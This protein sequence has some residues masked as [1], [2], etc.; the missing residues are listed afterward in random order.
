MYFEESSIEILVE[1]YPTS[2]KDA[3]KDERSTSKLDIQRYMNLATS[4]L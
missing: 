1:L 2:K 4:T 3:N